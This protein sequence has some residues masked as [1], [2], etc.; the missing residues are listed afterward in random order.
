MLIALL[1]AYL[2]FNLAAYH[3][4]KYKNGYDFCAEWLHS[5][6][7]KH[8]TLDKL[9]WTLICITHIPTLIA[10]EIDER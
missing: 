2:W 3:Q 10:L 7:V 6:E 5:L 4:L 9:L 1:L 8:P